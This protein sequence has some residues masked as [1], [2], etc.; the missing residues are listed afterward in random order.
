MAFHKVCR[1]LGVQLAAVALAGAVTAAGA[2]SEEVMVYAG[3]GLRPAI[4]KLAAQFE[5]KTGST[6]AIDYGGSGQLLTHFAARKAGDVFIP[7]SMVYFEKLGADVGPVKTVVAH[8]PVVGVAAAKAGEIKSFE[9]LARPGVKVGLGDPKAMALGR[10]A[11]AI[12]KA[13]P[14]GEK[15]LANTVV[16]AA[17]VKQLALYVEQG[18]VD[19]AIVGR[20]DAVRSNGKIVMVPIPAD[21]YKAEIV[22]VGVLSTST[23]PELAQAFAD[24][25]ASKEGVAVFE[26]MGFLPVEAARKP[27]PA[28]AK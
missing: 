14:I 9:D 8:V 15:I 12:L 18:D 27:E 16:R 20:S 7:G 25:V 3:A 26:T 5:A 17:T 4:D 1:R 11:E 23:H 6:V 2:R 22:G 19:A 28:A 24:L 21:L 10:T 13:S